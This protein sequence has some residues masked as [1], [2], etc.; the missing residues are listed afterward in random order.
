MRGFDQPLE[1]AEPFD[2][3]LCV[4]NSLALAADAA[5]VRRALGHMLAAVRPGG[6]M[7][8]H[9]LNLWRLPDGPCVWQKRRRATLPQ[10][11]VLIVKG[12]HRAGVRGY[13]E[14]VV[15]GLD[16]EPSGCRPSRRR[17]LGLE[18]AELEGRPAAAAPRK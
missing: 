4:G 6:A 7:V 5:A 12:V 14:F 1:A 11:E 13:V 10:G 9:L 15:A 17:W 3:V 2:A 8:V 16:A 18:A